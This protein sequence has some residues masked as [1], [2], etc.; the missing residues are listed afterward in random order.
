MGRCRNGYP[1][2]PS[3]VSK[4]RLTGTSRIPLSPRLSPRFR[5][6]RA[7]SLSMKCQEHIYSSSHFRHM[8]PEVKY[9]GGVIHK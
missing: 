9:L 7:A 2:M 3:L 5:V 1:E 4:A 8:S 6:D